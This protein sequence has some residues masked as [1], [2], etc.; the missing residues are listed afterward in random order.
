M[1]SSV[2]CLSPPNTYSYVQ[3]E[4]LGST[5]KL[6]EDYILLTCITN[7]SLALHPQSMDGL[8]EPF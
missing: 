5:T 1:E 4:N 7:Q 8:E 6:V 3:E 2:C